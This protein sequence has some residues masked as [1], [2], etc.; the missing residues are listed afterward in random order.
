[1]EAT[2][3]DKNRGPVSQQVY[4]DKMCL[5]AQKAQESSF[6]SFTDHGRRNLVVVG[7]PTFRPSLPPP[8]TIKFASKVNADS[9][10]SGRKTT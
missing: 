9:G 6:A 2:K 3:E 8:H 1:M 5:S 10:S 4:H 7:V